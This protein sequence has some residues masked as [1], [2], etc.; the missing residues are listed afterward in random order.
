MAQKRVYF[1]GS[2]KAEGN[3][4]MKSLLGGKGANVAEVKTDPFRP[5][6]VFVFDNT[7]G[8]VH[9]PVIRKRASA[10]LRKDHLC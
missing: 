9:R 5:F 8:Y 1:F 2:G 6:G 3:A 4:T 10:P 7:A